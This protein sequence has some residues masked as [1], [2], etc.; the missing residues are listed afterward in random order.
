MKSI[1][2][3]IAALALGACTVVG[4]VGFAA[5]NE[6]NETSV[7]DIDT[8]MAVAYE[9]YKT[10]AELEGEEVLTYD[11]WYETLLEAAKG[12]DGKD[13]KDGADGDSA[14]DIWLDAGNTGTE[15]DFLNWLKGNSG[16]VGKSA[17]QIWL[18][19]GN[20]GTEQDFLNSLKGA[21]GDNGTNGTNGSNG[22]KGDTGATGARGN[23]IETGSQTPT[24]TDGYIAGDL[25]INTSDWTVH[26][27]N[28]TDWQN[29]GSIKGADAQSD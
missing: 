12:K 20:T 14:Y 24:S 2:K 13:G 19:E 26:S 16:G 9:M 7:N 17:Y 23:K 3:A 5:C 1:K 6:K 4:I 10:D 27:F 21:K 28:G 18:D 15:Q 29:L 22:A 8:R 25:F 11:E